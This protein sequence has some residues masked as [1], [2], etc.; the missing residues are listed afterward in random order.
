MNTNDTFTLSQILI[1]TLCVLL[2]FVLI[3]CVPHLVGYYYF[4]Q[5]HFKFHQTLYTLHLSAM[6]LFS[7]KPLSLSTA[8]IYCY[9]I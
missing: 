9:V 3:F 2:V 8:L 1:C 7:L 4:P 5:P 6:A